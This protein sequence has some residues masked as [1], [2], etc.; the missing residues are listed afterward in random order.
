MLVGR[1]DEAEGDEVARGLL[2]VEVERETAGEP[3]EALGA[4]EGDVREEEVALGVAGV[5]FGGE[6]GNVSKYF[7]RGHAQIPICSQLLPKFEEAGLPTW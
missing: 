4:R 1:L 6:R 2:R 7:R 3:V 5:G